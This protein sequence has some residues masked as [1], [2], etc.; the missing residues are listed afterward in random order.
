VSYLAHRAQ[1]RCGVLEALP[2]PVLKVIG[3]GE[4]TNQLMRQ[5]AIGALSSALLHDLAS[6]I[7]SLSFA[8]SEVSSLA[9]T[10][11]LSKAVFDAEVAG[12]QVV[13]LF[14]QMRK[15][16]R[17]GVVTVRPVPVARLA[18]NVLKLVGGTVR[19]RA[20]LRCMTVIPADV[21]VEVAEALFAQ[22]LANLVRNAAN[23]SPRGGTV[24]LDVVVEPE[25]VSFI[26]TDDGPGVDPDIA[27]KMF[28]P[29]ASGSAT[30]TGLGLAISAYVI[31]LLKG[32]ITYRRDPQRGAC[33]TATVPRIRPT[34]LNRVNELL[35]Q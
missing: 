24:D 25:T 19:E 28:E 5:A 22:V 3:G 1:R 35:G 6:T 18:E 27:D 21:T 29:F 30:G 23:A 4:R 34:D 10:P 2:A 13:Q 9:D 8:L 33:F 7:Q 12:E 11:G 26:I 16:I 14:V 17:D 32:R 31:E 15:F 20:S